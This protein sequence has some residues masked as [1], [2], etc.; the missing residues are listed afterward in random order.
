MLQ[1]CLVS[2][3]PSNL[4]IGCDDKKVLAKK[5]A[6]GFEPTTCWKWSFHLRWPFNRCSISDTSRDFLLL[7]EVSTESPSAA[8]SSFPGFEP[9][10]L[11]SSIGTR[12]T[13][14]NSIPD[15]TFDDWRK[16]KFLQKLINSTFLENLIEKV[17]YVIF[18]KKI[19]NV[20]AEFLLSRSRHGFIFSDKKF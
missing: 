20:Y 6:A 12:D 14:E 3:S 15:K 5:I 1:L 19:K 16:W 11:Q 13:S 7:S 4:I 10:T 17:F 18:L 2:F 8:K 9:V